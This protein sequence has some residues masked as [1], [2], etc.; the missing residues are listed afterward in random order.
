VLAAA[1]NLV[2]RILLG[3]SIAAAVYV[4]L[5]LW[6]VVQM[7]DETLRAALNRPLML[8][9]VTRDGI[10]H[11]ACNCNRTLRADEVPDLV[12]EALV[13]VED[14]RFYQHGGVDPW[15]LAR[16]AAGGFAEGGS[17]L[18]QQLAKG[19]VTGNYDK[20]QRKI[21]EAFFAWRIEKM[22]DKPDI[23]RLYLSRVMFGMKDGVPIFG[24]RDAARVYFGRAPKDLTVAQTALL[25]GL[26]KA[27]TTYNPV[28][29]PEAAAGR[30]RIVLSR[31]V[32]QS[33][34][35]DT[36]IDVEAALPRSY[37][38]SPRRDRFLEDHLMAE[39]VELGF[40][41][42]PGWYRI[43]STIDPIAQ[44]QARRVIAA[45]LGRRRRDGARRAALVTLDREGR[46]LA[47]YGG[48]DYRRSAFN[49]ATQG[50]RQAASTAKLATYLA[51]LEEGWKA[52][53]AVM[54]DP[55][56]LAGEFTPRNSD[57]R[58]RGRIRM[59]RCFAESRNVCTMYLAQDLGMRQVSRMS[60]RLG[61]TVEG[62]PGQSIVLGAAETTLMRNTAAYAALTNGARV[63]DPRAIGAVLGAYGRVHHQAAPPVGRAVAAPESTDAMRRM[64]RLAVT[65]GTGREAGFAGGRAFG[66]TGTSQEN[67]DAWFIGFTGEDITT[68]VWVGPEE[69]GRMR[70]ISGGDLPAQ[71]FGRYN[72][73]LIERFRDYAA[74]RRP[75]SR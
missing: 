27:S 39:F 10:G 32:S 54:D 28:E 11:S 67:R 59:D 44:Y 12:A 14:H 55:A 8:V 51:A 62:T 21:H 53:Y 41:D 34:E 38:A 16:A 64:L 4:G 70:N 42:R 9:E 60:A 63:P 33:V 6:K 52:H 18:T 15:A 7:D 30:A 47:L 22:Y 74:G 66:K 17:T 37:K 71:I 24:L 69:G 68:G 13:A 43:V 65:E 50:E 57:G 35:V 19:A 36:P 40:S 72:R 31:M 25:V 26:L 58:Y 1:V 49:I 61:L 75:L 3:L 46:I 48:R 56:A 45:E 2:L 20:L 23:L 5:I 73:N 29:N